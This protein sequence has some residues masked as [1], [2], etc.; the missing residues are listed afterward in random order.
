MRRSVTALLVVAGT[1][2][3]GAWSPQAPLAFAVAS[4]RPNPATGPLAAP[5]SGVQ[6][7]GGWYEPRAT[8]LMLIRSAYSAF[9]LDA[10]VIGGPDWLRTTRF[11]VNAR[12]DREVTRAETVAMM[13]QLL[14]DRFKLA[15]HTE[16]RQVEVYALVLAR[17]DGR[18]GPGLRKPALDCDALRKAAL[19]RDGRFVPSRVPGQ[20]AFCGVFPTQANGIQRVD[21]GSATIAQFMGAI[22]GAARGT[23]LVDRTGLSGLFDVT[24]QFTEGAAP[25]D[26]NAPGIFV[27]LEEQLGLKLDRRQEPMEVLVIDRAELPT[28]N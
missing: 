19:D 22:R 7:G 9:P 28:P 25:A 16:T 24:L 18:L 26:A 5:P 23:P 17:P 2:T 3:M 20:G 14:A 1:V 15:V 6:P 8:L 4:I 13:Q 12:T 27:A 10:Q 11:E 21:A